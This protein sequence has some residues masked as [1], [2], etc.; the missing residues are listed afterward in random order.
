MSRQRWRGRTLAQHPGRPRVPL[1]AGAT[2]APPVMATTGTGG[3]PVAMAVLAGTARA[4]AARRPTS[5]PDAVS[6][7]HQADAAPYLT[8]RPPV[9]LLLLAAKGVPRPPALVPCMHRMGIA[10]VRR[11]TSEGFGGMK[12][13]VGGPGWP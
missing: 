10:C 6:A 5:R 12:A 9:G 8:P 3:T 13:P 1:R 2:T 4:W 7:G 11:R